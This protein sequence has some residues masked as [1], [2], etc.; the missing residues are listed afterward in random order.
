MAMKI[1]I[2][3]GLGFIGTN[4]YFKLNKTYKIKI[5]DNFKVKNNICFIDKKK[6]IRC[7]IKNSKKIKKILTNFDVIINL[8]GQTGVIESNDKP[9][10]CLSD[11]I[12]GYLNILHSANSS[13][14]KI[15]IINA[16]TAGAIYG[17]TKK[18]CGETDEMNPISYYGLSK[19]FN[20]EQSNIFNKLY[21]LK[22]VNLRFANVYGEFSL[23][24]KSLVHNSIKSYIKRKKM[25]IFGNGNQTRDFIYVGDLVEIIERSIK[26]KTGSYNIASGKS[27]SVNDFINILKNNS[28]C[29]NYIKVK[30]NKGE[31][32]D[33]RINNKKLLNEINDSKFEF[34]SFEQGIK[35]TLVWYRKYFS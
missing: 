35:N 11:N 9:H 26:F 6:I 17:D 12:F 34:T 1:A 8:A 24:K 31:V 13:N 20:E 15:K 19:K 22:I 2:V 32:K 10:E 33:V 30:K 16:S 7:D 21:K 14:K 29:P 27:N 28:A 18:I 5:I 4:L 23:H 25:F 3:G